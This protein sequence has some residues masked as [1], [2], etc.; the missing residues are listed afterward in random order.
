MSEHD[1]TTVMPVEVRAVDE[2]QRKAVMVVCR[3]GEVS[4]R[5]PRREKF[6]RGAF[7]RSVSSHGHKVPF[8]VRHS[9]GTGDLPQGSVVAM[10]MRWDTGDDAELR[11]ELHFLDSS[12][13]WMAFYRARD[14]ELD[15]GS[16]GF[17]AVEERTAGGVR[18]IVQARLHH[19]MLLN[20]G[21]ATPAYDSP[22]IVEVRA[23]TLRRAA[24]LLKISWDPQLAE[25]GS[26]ADE[27][28][29]L[30]RVD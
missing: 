2:A 14:G 19:V 11:A 23:D 1:E 7:T 24:E 12:E 4:E 25:R 9:D 15:G 16:V 20:R 29:R 3:Y 30:G 21:E 17:R 8:T 27:L 22:K 26:L 5:L 28:A 13:G 6:A 10:P 18:E